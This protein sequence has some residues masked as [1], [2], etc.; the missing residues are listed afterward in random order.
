M[1]VLYEIFGSPACVDEI[2]TVIVSTVTTPTPT[3]ADV[4]FGFI[5]NETHEIA[6]IRQDGM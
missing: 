4:A 2:K 3:L 1:A 5:Q 6:T